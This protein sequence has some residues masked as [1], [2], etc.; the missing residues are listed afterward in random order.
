[1]WS[2]ESMDLQGRTLNLGETALLQDEVYPFTWNLQKNGIMLSTL[3]NHW[4]MNNPNLVYAHYTSVEET[5][6]FARK[7]A[8][9]YKVLQ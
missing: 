9:G 7:V 2:F 5:L 8:E 1:M 3:H 4:L 6:S